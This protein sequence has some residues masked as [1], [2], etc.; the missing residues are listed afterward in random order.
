MRVSF[1]G[2]P[3]VELNR[4]KPHSIRELI[5]YERGVETRI[6][7]LRTGSGGAE[8]WRIT[9]SAGTE[10][11]SIKEADVHSADETL[12]LLEE[13]GRSLTAAGWRSS[14]NWRTG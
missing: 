6:Y 9:E 1:I 10:A 14:S 11:R 12:E 5:R 4:M 13:I 2:L 7:Q 8:L 3:E